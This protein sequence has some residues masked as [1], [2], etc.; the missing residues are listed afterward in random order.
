MTIVEVQTLAERLRT[1]AETAENEP[2]KLTDAIRVGFEAFQKVLSDSTR[3]AH[4]H[5][6]AH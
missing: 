5:L 3:L 6:K 1:I 4:G 2:P